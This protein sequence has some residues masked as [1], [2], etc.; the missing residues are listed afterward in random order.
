[1]FTASAARRLAMYLSSLASTSQGAF[2]HLH[3]SVTQT[4]RTAHLRTTLTPNLHCSATAMPVVSPARTTL[5]ALDPMD[6]VRVAACA[7]ELQQLW[8]PS[9][10]EGVVLVDKD[11]LA[12]RLRSL[13]RRGWLYL[14]WHPTTA[15][16]C[17]GGEPDRGEASEAFPIAK[18]VSSR[19]APCFVF[20]HLPRSRR[21][22]RCKVCHNNDT[23]SRVDRYCGNCQLATC[24][25]QFC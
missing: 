20:L 22:S 24:Q 4:K 1:M 2:P 12:L 18:L 23:F 14:S 5:N 8:V 25:S 17:I 10:V 6:F 9:K 11:T 3:R 21:R 15:R 19:R 16:V 13:D 7:S